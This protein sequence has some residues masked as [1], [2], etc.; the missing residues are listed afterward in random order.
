[1][2]KGIFVFAKLWDILNTSV[3]SASSAN[4]FLCI[5]E[6]LNFAII[7]DVMT[8]SFSAPSFWLPGKSYEFAIIVAFMETTFLT[9]L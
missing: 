1:M 8:G 6:S 2:I 9:N 5:A 7:A 3:W 4:L